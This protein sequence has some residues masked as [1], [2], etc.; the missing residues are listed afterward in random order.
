MPDVADLLTELSALG[1]KIRTSRGRLLVSQ[2]SA[3]TPDL[4]ARLSASKLD[5][6]AAI[7]GA[8]RV[9]EPGEG[10]DRTARTSALR[11]SGSPVGSVDGQPYG[12]TTP[13]FACGSADFWAATQVGFWVC[14]QCHAPDASAEGLVRIRV[15]VPGAPTPS[16]RPNAVCLKCYGT[17]FVRLRDGRR[18]VCAACERPQPDQIVGEDDGVVGG[19]A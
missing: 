9:E 17:R 2:S 4:R 13:C 7:E 16:A 10:T 3:V 18:S 8:S 1:V 5:L 19:A 6:I 14:G 11:R 15:G 12:P